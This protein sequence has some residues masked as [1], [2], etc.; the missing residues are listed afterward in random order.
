VYTVEDGKQRPL[1]SAE[2][3]RWERATG[4]SVPLEP[5]PDSGPGPVERSVVEECKAYPLAR[6]R[7][8]IYQEARKL[9]Q[10][11]DTP[12]VVGM[13]PQCSRQLVGL[14]NQLRSKA[15]PRAKSLAVVRR[16]AS[17]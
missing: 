10:L 1:T 12:E 5:K 17:K 15:T 2:R 13:H 8:A 9:A 11:L 7:P 3:K 14:L 16:M 4:R 6:E